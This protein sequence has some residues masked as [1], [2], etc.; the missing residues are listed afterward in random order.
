[1]T[2]LVLNWQ[3]ASLPRELSHYSQMALAW[4]KTL[5]ACCDLVHDDSCPWNVI[6]VCQLLLP[7][8]VM[9]SLLCLVPN[10]HQEFLGV[11]IGLVMNCMR[12]VSEVLPF[13]D[14]S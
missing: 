8:D 11:L 5:C 14:M 4:Y 10:T 13:Q 6:I 2:Y 1:M 12:R 9:S 3:L 7:R